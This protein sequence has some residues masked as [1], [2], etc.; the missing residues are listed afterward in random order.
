MKEVHPD[1][2]INKFFDEHKWMV[3]EPIKNL[4]YTNDLNLDYEV[5][6]KYFPLNKK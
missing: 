5:V 1:I 2:D 3:M 6:N 4:T